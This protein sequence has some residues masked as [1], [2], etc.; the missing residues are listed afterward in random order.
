M[1]KNLN[2]AGLNYQEGSGGENKSNI[3]KTYF[4]IDVAFFI[5][6]NE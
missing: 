3:A 5:H 6:L 1:Y 2:L 4:C